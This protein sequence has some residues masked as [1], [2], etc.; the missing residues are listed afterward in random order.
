MRVKWIF[1]NWDEKKR[2]IESEGGE[3]I[4]AETGLGGELL[5]PGTVIQVRYDYGSTTTFY[6][7]VSR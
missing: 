3:V 5:S 7:K 1:F 6:M 2:D 4:G